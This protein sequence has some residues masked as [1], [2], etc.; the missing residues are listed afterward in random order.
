MRKIFVI[1]ANEAM[2]LILLSRLNDEILK[3]GL[4]SE[5]K[6]DL[7]TLQTELIDIV[8]KITFIH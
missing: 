8:H 5:N 6:D 1:N 7:L 3:I 2:T 4:N